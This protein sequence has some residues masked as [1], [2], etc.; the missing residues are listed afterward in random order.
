MTK[1]TIKLYEDSERTRLDDPRFYEVNQ[2]NLR[3][4][5]LVQTGENEA[6]LTVK[7]NLV[8]CF[9]LI[10][11]VLQSALSEHRRITPL[12]RKKVYRRIQTMSF[13]LTCDTQFNAE[14]SELAMYALSW[15]TL[16]AS[17]NAINAIWTK[18]DSEGRDFTHDELET[19]V[20]QL[21]TIVQ[22]GHNIP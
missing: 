20:L 15:E 18:T 3:L 21:E 1:L 9:R 22:E 12:E 5:Y 13:F 2:I 19:L 6:K 4:G 14:P 17:Y 16:L 11:E 10:E 8:S 7:G